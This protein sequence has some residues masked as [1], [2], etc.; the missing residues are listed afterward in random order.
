MIQPMKNILVPTDFSVFAQYAYD[1]ALQFARRFGARIHLLHVADLPVNWTALSDAER[2]EHSVVLQRISEVERMLK[3]WE[4]LSQVAEV[5]THYMGGKLKDAVLH[6]VQE[7]GVEL[8]IMGSHGMSGKSEYFI[9]SNTQK[10]IRTIH[11]PVLV[12]KEPVRHINF[13][14]VVF[15][16]SFNENERKPFL[17]FKSFVKH[18]IPTIHLVYV[19]TAALFDPPFI[20]NK[21][22]MEDFRALCLPFES[23]VHIFKDLTVERGIRNIA[24]KLGVSLIGISNH[25]RHPLKRMLV[26][27]NVEALVN[28]SCLP[29]LS[30]DYEDEDEIM[31]S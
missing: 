30:V 25:Y 17:E 2:E 3:E 24:Q 15:A 6:F 31:Q 10:V 8:V 23:Q 29:V 21:E 14:E 27:S 26:G 11:R 19:D 7:H 1:A 9:G 4:S 5:E 18:F 20:V 22:A 13:K 12:V 28:H 16:S